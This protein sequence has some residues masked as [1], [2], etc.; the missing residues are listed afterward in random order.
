[1]SPYTKNWTPADEGIMAARAE[2]A[3][4]DPATQSAHQQVIAALVQAVST[5]SQEDKDRLAEAMEFLYQSYPGTARNLRRV[6]FTARL[7]A[8]LIEVVDARPEMDG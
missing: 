4:R 7:F 2:A 3:E 8:E 5:A 6:P 1:M